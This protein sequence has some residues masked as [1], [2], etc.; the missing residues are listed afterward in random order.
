MAILILYILPFNSFVRWCCCW[1]TLDAYDQSEIPCFWPRQGPQ[2]TSSH[3]LAQRPMALDGYN[4]A[5]QQLLAAAHAL[6]CSRIKPW[7]GRHSGTSCEDQTH[8]LPMHNSEYRY[9]E[10][11]VIMQSAE[12]WID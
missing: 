9:R 4:Q 12:L 3:V 8:A 5:N 7:F 10:R 1:W 11:K 2:K 6:V